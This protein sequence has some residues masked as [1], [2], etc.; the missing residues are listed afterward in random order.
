V[1]LALALTGNRDFVRLW[2]AQ[3]VSAV[4]SRFTRTA[5]P[6]LAISTLHVNATG[7]GILGALGV[8][9]AFLVGL[10][11]GAPIDRARKLPLLVAADVVRGVA[12]LS[13]PLAAWAGWLTPFHLYVVVAL[14][15]AASSVF[16]TA[17]FAFLPRVVSHADLVESNARLR[18]TDSIAEIAGP[19]IAGLAIQFLGA[20]VA[21]VVDGLSFFWSAT[22]LR[23]IS[24]PDPRAEP[25][26]QE[27]DDITTGVRLCLRHPEIRPLFLAEGIHAFA[28]GFFMALYMM[29]ALEVVSLD[30]GTIGLVI[31]VGGV[32]GLAGAFVVR[33]V[34]E[35]WGDRTALLRALA[36]G[37]V[38]MLA[39]PLSAAFPMVALPLLVIHQL[40]GDASFVAYEVVSGS[41]RQR[42]LR[43][44]D[45][46][47]AQ[48]AFEA[49]DAS[50]LTLGTLAAGVLGDALGVSTSLW[51]GIGL[52]LLAPV[53]LLLHR[54]RV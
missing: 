20:P 28:M 24:A 25:Q 17:D 11:A 46:G 21:I 35:R 9:P 5:L 10:L 18:A 51:I 22:W 8:A 12:V 16:R 27:K 19:G 48:G 3:A 14:N 42:V 32:G 52:G 34:R 6:I 1:P 50:M 43:V 47:K 37:Q 53:P 29:F 36:A 15:G 54:A 4:G 39:I 26:L 33:R 30:A 41:L 7:V 38:M 31:G 40:L 44:E 45:L 49:L 2:I 23:G 13:I